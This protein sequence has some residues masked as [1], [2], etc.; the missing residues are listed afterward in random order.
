MNPQVPNP[1]RV[2]VIDD[3]ESIH[4]LVV[5]RLR[6]EGLEVIGED[7]GERGIERAVSSQPDVILLDIGL[8]NV[9]GFEVCRRLKEHPSTRN[10]PIIFLTGTTDTESKVRGLELAAGD[11]VTKPFDQVELRAP[12]RSG[13]RT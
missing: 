12:L 4:K 7:D 3:N 6:P 2:L 8:P 9:D 10:I 1:N 13:H 5:A 11:Y